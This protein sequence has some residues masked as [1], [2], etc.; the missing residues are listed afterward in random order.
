MKA[1]SR[2]QCFSCDGDDISWRDRE[3]AT[4]EVFLR[5]PF[6]SG[7]VKKWERCHT[8]RF[9]YFE[10]KR[11]KLTGFNVLNGAEQVGDTI[12]P[13]TNIRAYA[14]GRQTRSF[15]Q[16]LISRLCNHN[17]SWITRKSQDV[18][19]VCHNIDIWGVVY[20]SWGL[21]MCLS[22]SYKFQFPPLGESISYLLR[23]LN[24]R[25]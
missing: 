18:I 21:T 23:P 10:G 7:I 17:W 24:R 6:A 3:N 2:Q 15:P 4:P 14:S 12:I 8:A 16:D 13:S 19:S 20:C 11:L 5:Q 22:V 9:Q 25:R 1:W